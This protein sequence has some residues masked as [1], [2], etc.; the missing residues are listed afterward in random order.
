MYDRR[1][2][3]AIFIPVAGAGTP[4]GIGHGLFTYFMNKTIPGELNV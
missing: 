2:I 4:A 3:K 1:W